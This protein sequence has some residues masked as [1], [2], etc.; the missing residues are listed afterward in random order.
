MLHT[1]TDVVRWEF[2]SRLSNVNRCELLILL[3]KAVVFNDAK[4]KA[5]FQQ[6]WV[7]GLASLLCAEQL[8]YCSIEIQ[9]KLRFWQKHPSQCVYFFGNVAICNKCSFDFYF[10]WYSRQHFSGFFFINVF[11][12]LYLYSALLLRNNFLFHFCTL[13]T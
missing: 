5:V 4:V 10:I 13:R 12:K 6:M 8:C 7:W 11:I 3:I 1:D 9:K 2:G